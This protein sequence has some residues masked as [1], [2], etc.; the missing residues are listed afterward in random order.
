MNRGQSVEI[1]C[2]NYA[3]SQKSNHNNNIKK[4]NKRNTNICSLK[5]K[6]TKIQL[7]V[8]H[9][10]E[11]QSRVMQEFEMLIFFKLL[12]SSMVKLKAA[13]IVVGIVDWGEMSEDKSIL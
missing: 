13:E 3:H 9:R 11:P 7:K 12:P 1:I 2:S 10:S 5:T 8:K 4:N 6:S